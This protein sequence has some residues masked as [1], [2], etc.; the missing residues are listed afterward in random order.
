MADAANHSRGRLCHVVIIS[1]TNAAVIENTH[2]ENSHTRFSLQQHSKNPLNDYNPV[3][4]ENNLK[5]LAQEFQRGTQEIPCTHPPSTNE[6][7]AFVAELRAVN[8]QVAREL[9]QLERGLG[10]N[11]IE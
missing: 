7:K 5:L 10:D 6:L 2:T 1:T 8:A 9:T 11:G 3:E 4:L